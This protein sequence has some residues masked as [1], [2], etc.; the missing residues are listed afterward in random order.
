M[1][2]SYPR[3]CLP[4]CLYPCLPL[5]SLPIS[6]LPA[7]LPAFIPASRLPA[8]LSQPGS[9]REGVLAWSHQRL[10][11]KKYINVVFVTSPPTLP[12]LPLSALLLVLLLLLLHGLPL[13]L[14]PGPAFT[15]P[16]S[17]LDSASLIL[18]VLLLPLLAF[19]LLLLL[20]LLLPV[21]PLFRGPASVL[22]H[23]FLLHA[24]FPL[25]PPAFSLFYGFFS[26]A[27]VLTFLRLPHASP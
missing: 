8:S 3:A 26:P 11:M 20:L 18:F 15:P 21:V 4:V 23:T 14:V 25:H 9:R 27:L 22:A 1:I 19:H 7:S 10:S 12:L 24:S 16:A 17:A 13:F 2:V 6:L 5:P